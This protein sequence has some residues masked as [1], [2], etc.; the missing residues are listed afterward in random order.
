MIVRILV[1]T[2]VAM[3]VVA[4]AFTYWQLGNYD[5]IRSTREV[6]IAAP[7][8][9]VWSHLT[10]S[11]KR[12]DWVSGL[13]AVVPLSGDPGQTGARS[14][15]VMLREGRRFELE[16]EIIG[17]E[18]GAWLGLKTVSLASILTTTFTLEAAGPNEAPRSRTRVTFEQDVFHLTWQG[19]LFSRFLRMAS[20]ANAEHDLERLKSLV[21][22][23][24]QV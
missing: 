15:L 1:A 20:E 11:A 3:I 18:P 8:D 14:L 17:T 6:V 21:E 5:G 16:E 13:V 23:A 4:G 19:K 12:T 9:R 10:E 2:F 24:E 22:A 7:A